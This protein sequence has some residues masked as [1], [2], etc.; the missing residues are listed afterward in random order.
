MVNP[1]KGE[2]EIVLGGKTLTLRFTNN[3]VASLEHSLGYGIAHL[4]T[5]FS[6]LV[7]LS[8]VA[9]GIAAGLLHDPAYKRWTYP[10]V[11]DAIDPKQFEAYTELLVKGLLSWKGIDLDV[12]DEEPPTEATKTAEGPL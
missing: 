10:K 3:A 9:K 7:G 4:L 8:L 2:S 5:R 1:E 11:L 12:K 6:E